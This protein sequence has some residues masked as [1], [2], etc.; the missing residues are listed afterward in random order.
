VANDW[1]LFAVS[2]I[3]ELEQVIFT[4]ER[5]QP[6]LAGR[7]WVLVDNADFT[8]VYD[9][10]RGFVLNNPAF[11][12]EEIHIDYTQ[13]SRAGQGVALLSFESSRAAVQSSAEIPVSKNKQLA[14]RFIASAPILAKQKD[15]R[16]C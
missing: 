8:S 3:L 16:H 12:F 6:L 14:D 15:G 2:G 5:I 10:L 7:A 13:G 1:G 4:M 11:R 9:G